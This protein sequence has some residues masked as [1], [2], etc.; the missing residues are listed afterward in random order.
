[1]NQ[2]V[3][4]PSKYTP[5][6][7]PV[8][9]TYDLI[10][11]I[12]AYPVDAFNYIL[13]PLGISFKDTTQGSGEQIIYC[14][15]NM[16][17]NVYKDKLNTQTFIKTLAYLETTKLQYSVLGD[18][19]VPLDTVTDEVLSYVNYDSLFVVYDEWC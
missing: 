3:A 16:Q 2:G 5:Q 15:F 19:V 4:T 12:R 14:F 17:E 11:V 18:E 9:Q 1:M 8:E 6:T 13:V 7:L 10:D